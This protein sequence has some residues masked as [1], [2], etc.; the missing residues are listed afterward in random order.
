M[1]TSLIFP[2]DHQ[3]YGK[4]SLYG[5][6]KNGFLGEYML[7]LQQEHHRKNSVGVWSSALMNLADCSIQYLAIAHFKAWLLWK[8]ENSKTLKN[9]INFIQD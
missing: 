4:V 3:E 7:T 1:S 5:L 9:S 8:L 2:F 6:L